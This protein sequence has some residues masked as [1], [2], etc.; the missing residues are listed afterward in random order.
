MTIA[1]KLHWIELNNRVLILPLIS[2]FTKEANFPDNSYALT[3]EWANPFKGTRAQIIFCRRSSI[4]VAPGTIG[5]RKY[6]EG[7]LSIQRASN[8]YS[9]RGI[10]QID[11]REHRTHQLRF[12]L[13]FAC[14]FY[15]FALSSTFFNL[16]L[17]R[18]LFLASPAESGCLNL[19][20]V[21]ISPM[22]IKKEKWRNL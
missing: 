3:F 1:K 22:Q 7:R 9:I 17:L 5:R 8:S 2:G 20:F 16:I 18:M 15:Y 14:E 21:W 4:V 6:Y 11:K 13:Q 10:S 12:F 19:H